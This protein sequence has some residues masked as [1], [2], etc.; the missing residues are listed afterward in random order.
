MLLREAL[1]RRVSELPVHVL[2]ASLAPVLGL[3]GAAIS[4]ATVFTVGCAR[5]L[6]LFS[7]DRSFVA[8]LLPER[9]RWVVLLL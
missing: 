8:H 9:P 5:A 2:S 4:G 1:R 7:E 3:A 6:K